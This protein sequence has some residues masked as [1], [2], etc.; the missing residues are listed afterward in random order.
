[1]RPNDHDDTLIIMS[2]LQRYNKIIDFSYSLLRILNIGQW[3][4]LM[5][6]IT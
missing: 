3:F 6:S 1:M 2:G 5:I 4:T